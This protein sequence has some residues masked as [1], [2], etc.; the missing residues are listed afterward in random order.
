MFILFVLI[1][2]VLISVYEFMCDNSTAAQS[3]VELIH[4]N[5]GIDISFGYDLFAGYCNIRF[6]CRSDANAKTGKRS[7]GLRANWHEL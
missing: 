2:E 1:L 6:D 4:H 3:C 7:P 5:K